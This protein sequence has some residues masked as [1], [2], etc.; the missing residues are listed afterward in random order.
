MESQKHLPK[1]QSIIKP[2]YSVASG[3]WKQAVYQSNSAHMS[4]KNSVQKRQIYGEP[5][6]MSFNANSPVFIPSQHHPNP[7]P[8]NYRNEGNTG[9]QNEMFFSDYYKRLQH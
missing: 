9:G 5:R 6:I 2:D 4:F 7:A 1:Q 3:A 8:Q